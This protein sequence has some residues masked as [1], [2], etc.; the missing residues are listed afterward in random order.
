VLLP[1]AHTYIGK[2]CEIRWR[3][4]A[5]N[6]QT[7]IAPV[8]D[9]TYVP[10]YGAFLITELDDIRLDCIQSLRPVEEAEAV[11]SFKVCGV[12]KNPSR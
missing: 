12:R 2:K 11:Q 6:Q 3:D 8:C 7:T 5:G 9:V 10:L 1:E 4:R